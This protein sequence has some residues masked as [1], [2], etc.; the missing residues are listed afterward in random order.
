MQREEKQLEAS[1]DAITQKVR[2]LKNSLTTFLLKLEHEYEVLNWPTVLD[3]FAL[4]SSQ[5][6]SLNKI[7]KSDKCP[8]LRNR[9]LLA[10]RLSADHDPELEK[11]T[12]GRVLAFNHEV[13]PDYLRTKPEPEVEERVNQMS[14]K[15]S[16]LP[17]DALQKQITALNKIS[18]HIL[19]IINTNREEW[20]SEVNAKQ[21][22]PQTSSLTDTNALI[23]AASF[24]KGLKALRRSDSGSG[25]PTPPPTIPTP[26]QPQ[27]PTPNINI[28]K[29]PSSIKTTIK[30]AGG[31]HPY[32]RP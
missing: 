26:Q 9:V 22:Q 4:I 15:A 18:N 17:P 24:G 14:V 5:L 30:S 27:I 20:E 1:L 3:S 23:A 16:Q 10:L 32:Q 28:S 8:M 31:V 7:L 21:Q 11:L 6:N 19:D 12:E 2:D 13:V 25:G 29:A